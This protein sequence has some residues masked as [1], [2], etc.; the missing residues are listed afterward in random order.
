MRKTVNEK[1]QEQV[2]ARLL[3]LTDNSVCSDCTSRGPCW[4]SL[5]FGVFICFN[6]S[7]EH[8]HLGMHITRVRS[9]KIDNWTQEELEQMQA[10]GNDWA[11]RY[12]EGNKAKSTFNKPLTSASAQ[13]RRSFI[14]DKY[15][16]KMWVDESIGH[17]VELFR[18]A[19]AEGKNAYDFVRSQSSTIDQPQAR[20]PEL[21]KLELNQKEEPATQPG[22]K[23]PAAAQY[24]IA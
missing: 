5:D 2:F 22:F 4:V 8:R 9:T 13:Q 16:K 11:N 3:N 24:P 17:P 20:K 7:G 18:Q 10:V 23:H 6:C 14:R 21:A 12:W 15:L 19:Y 1:L